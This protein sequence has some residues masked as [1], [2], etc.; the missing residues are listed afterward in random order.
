MSV[1]TCPGEL[2]RG[3]QGQ[4]EVILEGLRELLS[5]FPL[6]TRLKLFSYQL[7]SVVDTYILI[8]LW[9]DF[10]VA[11]YSPVEVKWCSVDKFCR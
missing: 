8:M 1:G 6:V 10:A 4:S 5:S 2:P 11:E 7:Y 3:L 9:N